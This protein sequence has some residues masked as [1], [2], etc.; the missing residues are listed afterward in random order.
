MKRKTRRGGKGQF[1]SKR[2]NRRGLK[3]TNIY[4]NV[5]FPPVRLPGLISQ[6]LPAIAVACLV[7]PGSQD[8][9]APG[10]FPSQLRLVGDT[11]T[12]RQGAGEAVRVTAGRDSWG[13]GGEK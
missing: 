3:R 4:C 10:G 12:G 6:P 5:P 11:V 13:M 2:D 1:E 9:S 7:P 8:S